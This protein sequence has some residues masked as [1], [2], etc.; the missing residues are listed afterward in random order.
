MKVLKFTSLFILI[1]LAKPLYA[2]LLTDL[3]SC[4]Q[5]Y[6][7]NKGDA[8]CL[9]PIVRSLVS[10]QSNGS[11]SLSAMSGQ[12]VCNEN[13]KTCTYTISENEGKLSSISFACKFT[14]Q[15]PDNRVYGDVFETGISAETFTNCKNNVCESN[16]GRL[17]VVLD[18]ASQTIIFTRKGGAGQ[19][20]SHL[21]GSYKRIGD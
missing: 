16:D 21:V 6:K 18:P 11:N 13:W 19:Y 10:S 4:E 9:F 2:D 12:Y 17:S 8:S 15:M 3:N 20:L 7:N 5:G 14:Q 1:L